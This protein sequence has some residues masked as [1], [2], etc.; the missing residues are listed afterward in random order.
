[1]EQESS[2][3]LE[4]FDY[5]IPKIPFVEDLLKEIIKRLKRTNEKINFLAFNF[6][7]Y[8]R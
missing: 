6:A 1:M 5:D 3:D 2:T 8:L 4:D 7:H